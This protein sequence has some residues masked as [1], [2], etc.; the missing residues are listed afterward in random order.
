[1]GS[2]QD[3]RDVMDLVWSRKIRPVI[4]RVLPLSAGRE[5]VRLLEEGR[6]FGKVV[7]EP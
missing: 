3:F 1:M 4:D 2:H 5:A 7:L 6:K